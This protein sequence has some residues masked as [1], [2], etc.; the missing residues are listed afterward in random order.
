[1][2]ALRRGT[3]KGLHDAPFRGA[4]HARRP[5]TAL[6]VCGVAMLVIATILFLCAVAAAAG[7]L[8]ACREHGPRD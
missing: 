8:A 3:V 4:S 1:M 2:K 6:V 5:G 7:T